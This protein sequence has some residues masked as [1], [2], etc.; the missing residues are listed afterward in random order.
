MPEPAADLPL[1][2]PTHQRLLELSPAKDTEAEELR[3]NLSALVA[4]DR[5]LWLGGDEG[6]SLYRLDRLGD[7]HYG[8]L[9]AVKLRDFGLAGGKDDGES[10]LE[11]L[12][13]DGDRLWMVGSQSLR[14]RKY[15]ATA[16][17]LKLHDRQS[18]NAHVLGCLRLAFDAAEGRDALTQALASDRR[19]APFLAIPI[20]DNGLDIEGI[21]ARGE[22][23]L[24]RL[25]GP[26]LRGIALVL[27]LRLGGLDGDGPTLSLEAHRCRYLSLS[28]LAVRDLAVVPGSDDV[29][30]LAGPTMDLAGPC[31]LHR[32]R[33]ALGPQG[34]PP[35]D[36]VTLET[37]EPLLWIR[38]GRPGRPGQGSDKPE[39][40]DVQRRGDQLLA[41][42][43]YDDPVAAR[44]GAKGTSTRLDGY[45]LPD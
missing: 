11:G 45:G 27:D 26:V 34:S 4:L 16:G 42:V 29:L 10:D 36:G 14:R 38:D 6:R 15:D 19:I 8:N 18:R 37:T 23:V 33:N 12:A 35:K 43:A 20:K 31:Y 40:L 24:V 9:S 32:W 22:R 2:V 5:V 3:Q 7:H 30:V 28:G 41:W 21:A 44:I 17:S 13:R 1:A 39:G 25:R